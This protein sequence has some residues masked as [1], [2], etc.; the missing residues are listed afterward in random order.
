MRR[1]SSILAA[2][3]AIFLFAPT[4][5]ATPMV[6]PSVPQQGFPFISP[7]DV[8]AASW[9]L[10]DDTMDLTIAS[11]NPNE[12]RAMASI[13]KIMTALLVV[14]NGNLS[15]MVTI[16]DRAAATG[17][18]EIDLVA[19]EQ[20]SLDGLLKAI[21]IH[22]ANDAA[23]AAA[24]HI[25]GSVE[26]F[27]ALM[28]RRAYELGMRNTSFANPHGL[29]APGHYTTASD[30]LVLTR[31]AMRNPKFAE[32]TRSKIVVMPAAPDGT[33]RRGTTT[34]LMLDWY[35]GTI[36]V[37]TGFTSRALLTYVSVAEREG[38][39]LYA[40]L[41]GSEGERGHFAD[42]T[43]LF[44]Y[45]FRRLG[46]YG[47]AV[48]GAPYVASTGRAKPDPLLVEADS[49]TYVHLAGQGL[50]LALPAPPVVNAQ[51]EPPPVAELT[52]RS[53]PAPRGTLNILTFWIR[54]ALDA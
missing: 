38:R 3:L 24:E 6:H 34:N 33:A 26:E 37:K 19:G 27:V 20:I 9:I 45:G 43:K 15:D 5:M 4:A 52:R 35:E 28:N 41:L 29:D 23:T 18:K 31:Q 14:E 32:V 2:G 30:M 50:N 53:E 17:E 22:S 8:S 12:E 39:R 48:T 16:S 54:S 10:Y 11:E 47:T 42:A 25:S 44:E 36:G 13:T 7:P 40:V 1:L 46:F 51:P 21:L 49:E